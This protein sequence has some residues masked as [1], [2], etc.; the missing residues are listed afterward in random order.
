MFSSTNNLHLFP[1]QQYFPSSSSSSYHHHLVAPPPLSPSHHPEPVYL[2]PQ[3][4]VLSG[5]GGP[6]L[7]VLPN[8]EDQGRMKNEHQ[9]VVLMSQNNGNSQCF[10]SSGLN[11]F[12][13][14]KTSVKK[15]RH[16]KIYTAQGLR[17]RRVRLSID[18]SRKFFDLQDMLGYDKASKTLDWLLTKSRKAIKELT[19][20]RN[21]HHITSSSKYNFDDDSEECEVISNDEAEK[22]ML[23]KSSSK[24]NLAFHDVVAKESRAKARARARERTK[25]KM[26]MNQQFRSPPLP[27]PPS[28][29]PPPPVSSSSSSI[30]QKA[31]VSSDQ[32][33]NIIG[34]M[35][36]PSPMITSSSGYQKNLVISKGDSYYNNCNNFYFPSNLPPNWDINIDSFA[37]PQ[38]GYCTIANIDSLPG[39]SNFFLS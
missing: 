21:N 25:E 35:W 20:T 33:S 28:S 31:I 10:S 3:D 11:N 37:R 6:F 15:D 29:L 38:P 32:E 16:S 7:Q 34:I 39:I 18:I 14:K 12:L 8:Q 30:V 27:L 17:D 9:E 5:V 2:G 26:I 19:K 36:K 24:K 13:T 23:A 4:P 22:I 1:L